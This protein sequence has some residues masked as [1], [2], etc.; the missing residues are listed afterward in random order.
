MTL[1]HRIKLLKAKIKWFV[2]AIDIVIKN[3]GSKFEKIEERK[4]KIELIFLKLDKNANRT[5]D[6]DYIIALTEYNLINE[7]SEWLRD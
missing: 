2:K 4:K 3:E 5:T 6:I 1:L 7:I